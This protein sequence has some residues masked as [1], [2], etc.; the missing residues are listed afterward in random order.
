M[1][2]HVIDSE[3]SDLWRV[4]HIFNVMFLMRQLEVCLHSV[5]FQPGLRPLTEAN[6]PDFKCGMSCV[7]NIFT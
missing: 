5:C 4:T 3:A 2:S 7:P 1:F 6:S